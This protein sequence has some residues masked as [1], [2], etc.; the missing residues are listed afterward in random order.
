MPVAGFFTRKTTFPAAPRP[1]RSRSQTADEIDVYLDIWGKN[2]LSGR[3]PWVDSYQ[4]RKWQKRGHS[5]DALDPMA[6]PY[7][8][9]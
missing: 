8:G 3:E 4:P 7:S 6:V 5:R 9:A 1:A 2:F